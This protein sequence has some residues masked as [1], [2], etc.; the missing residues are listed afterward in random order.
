MVAVRDYPAEQNEQ[1]VIIRE[2]GGS[3]RVPF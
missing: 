3:G 2:R 1:S